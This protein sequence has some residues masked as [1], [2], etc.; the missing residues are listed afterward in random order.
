MD[1]TR[2]DQRPLCYITYINTLFQNTHVRITVFYHNID[3]EKKKR[4]TVFYHNI[5]KEKKNIFLK[6]K[7]NVPYHVLCQTL[8]ISPSHKDTSY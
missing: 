5:D 7:L 6:S 3:K 2:N 8:V 1:T 4:I